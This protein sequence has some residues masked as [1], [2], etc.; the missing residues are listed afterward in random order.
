MSHFF[1]EVE[2]GRKSK[3][4]SH[5]FR[6][7][8]SVSEHILIKFTEN[9]MEMQTMNKPLTYLLVLRL[10]K[11]WFI[12]YEC[13]H[14]FTIGIN[15][16]IIDKIFKCMNGHYI[17]MFVSQK[18]EDN[19]N[20]NF[21]KPDK[22]EDD[23]KIFNKEFT[24]SLIDVEYEELK[25]PDDDFSVDIEMESKYFNQTIGELKDFGDDL[26]IIC[27]EDKI[28]LNSTGDNMVNMNT[29]MKFDDIL[30]YEIDAGLVINT[31]Y[32]NKFLQEIGQFMKINDELRINIKDNLPIK[33]SCL[34]NSLSLEDTNKYEELKSKKNENI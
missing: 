25:I 9:G 17:Q 5:I 24:L 10:D 7:L 32:N 11:S 34:I 19:L 15:N 14:Y 1:L 30:S 33:I 27:S 20:I 29:I 4:F 26:E 31:T 13:K 12:K 21:I 2:Q 16:E 18:D 6:N 28:Q 23:L 3:I 8:S 22:I